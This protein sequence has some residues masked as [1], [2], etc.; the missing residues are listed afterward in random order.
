MI[1]EDVLWTEKYRPKTVDETILPKSFKTMFNKYVE[2]GTIPNMLLSG[3]PGVG[4]TTIAKAMCEELGCDYIVLNGSLDA[5]IGVIRHD[6]A[7]F[8]SSVSFSGGRK[9]VIFDEADN[10]VSNVQKALRNFID[11]FS[12][13][14]AFIFTCNYKARIIEPLQSRL[15]LI[16]FTFSKEEQPALAAEFFKRV[17]GIL[18]KENVQYDKK[19]IAELTTKFFPDFR[20]VIGELQKYSALGKIDEGIFANVKDVSLTELFNYLAA[21]DFN[22]MRK[23]CSENSDQDYGATYRSIYDF[24]AERVQSKSMPGFIVSLAEYMDKHTRSID[25]EINIA[26]FLTEVMF[27]AVY[28]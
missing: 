6:V 16:E 9:V 25:P 17:I 8:A 4:K 21:K 12:A 23:W 3:G 22:S 19:V 5:G 11:E 14:C 2:T 1:R 28:K 27:E 18:D 13:N 7:A 26:A 15:S 10:L 20:K 24:A